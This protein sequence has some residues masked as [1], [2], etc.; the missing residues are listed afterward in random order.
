MYEN[1]HGFGKIATTY[2]HL[3]IHN[4]TFVVNI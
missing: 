2:R 4:R 1:S 3:K